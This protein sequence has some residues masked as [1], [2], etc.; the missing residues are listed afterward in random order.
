MASAREPHVNGALILFDCGKALA[1]PHAVRFSSLGRSAGRMPWQLIAIQVVRSVI[2]GS[3]SV[4]DLSHG[5]RGRT[6][7]GILFSHILPRFPALRHPSVM[8]LSHE[9]SLKPRVRHPKWRPIS[10]TTAGRNT[11]FT[12]G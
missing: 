5:Q 6:S 10:T 2:F 9:Q 11:K 3:A 8:Q 12:V 1:P 7:P 4:R